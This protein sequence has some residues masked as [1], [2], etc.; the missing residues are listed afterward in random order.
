MPYM[1]LQ[2]CLQVATRAAL[3]AG[4]LQAAHMGRPRTVD[5][6]RS[7]IDLVTEI[8][9][10]SERLI[11]KAITT[12]FPGHGYQGEEGA[13]VN[14]DSPYRWIV[15]PLDGTTNFV[16]GVPVFGISI[17]LLHH[18]TIVLGVIHDPTQREMFSAVKG[19]GAWLNGRRLRVSRVRRLEGS[20]L[21]TGF[22]VKFRK[23]PTRYLEW[24]AA[25]QSRTHAVRRMGSTAL[26]LAYV[27]AGRQDGFYEQDLW[28]W[29]IAAGLLLVEEAGGRV[30]DFQGRPLNLEDGRVVASNGHLHR[31]M[32]NVIARPGSL[33]KHFC[34]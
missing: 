34:K 19:R 12:K 7:A 8:D 16:H 1:S 2:A 23:D 26:S 22:S 24:F 20:L 10:A 31:A 14:P 6:K 9:K 25:F 4:K 28:P 29:D 33:N 17:G 18:G 5:T 11:S 15:D 21:S 3:R 27:A 32:L 30:S 13:N